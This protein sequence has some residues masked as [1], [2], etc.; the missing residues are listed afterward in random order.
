M[1]LTCVV[2]N[3]DKEKQ[4]NNNEVATVVKLG[5]YINY[6]GFY[7]DHVDQILCRWIL[8]ETIYIIVFY[9]LADLV[10]L[11]LTHYTCV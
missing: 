10:S 9:L 5:F 1:V 4:G 7:N 8:T 11:R 2:Y 6:L 3:V